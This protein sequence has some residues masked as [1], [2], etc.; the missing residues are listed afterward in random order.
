MYHCLLSKLFVSLKCLYLDPDRAF[1]C[2]CVSDKKGI[3]LGHIAIFK[4]PTHSV[5]WFMEFVS[6]FSCFYLFVTW[7][8]EPSKINSVTHNRQRQ[9]WLIR[10]G[11]PPFISSQLL[12]LQSHH[13]FLF[14]ADTSGTRSMISFCCGPSTSTFDRLF[15]PRY[16]TI[17]A[18]SCYLHVGILSAWMILA[19]RLSQ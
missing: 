16:G 19:T 11:K 9:V 5:S 2:I 8:E 13:N 4:K 3:Y 12:W 10:A 14:L 17:V 6:F 18:P 7:L 1:S 15:V